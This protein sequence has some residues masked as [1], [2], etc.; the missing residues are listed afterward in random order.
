MFPITDELVRAIQ[1]DHIRTALSRHHWSAF[2]PRRAGRPGRRATTWSARV[3]RAVA[4]ALHQL[5]SRIDA[6][7]SEPGT[8]AGLD[9]G[10]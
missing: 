2:D 9:A 4:R 10:G 8:L 1:E 3:R 5:A 6:G 7:T